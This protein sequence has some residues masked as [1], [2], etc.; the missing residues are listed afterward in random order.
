MLGN[1]LG[2]ELYLKEA[3]CYVPKVEGECADSPYIC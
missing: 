1:E 3:V 2:T